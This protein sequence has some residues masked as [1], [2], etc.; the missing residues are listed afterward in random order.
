MHMF[1]P[2]FLDNVLVSSIITWLGDDD[3]IFN[4]DKASCYITKGFKDFFSGKATNI[5][6]MDNKQFRSK[7]NWKFM[8]YLFKFSLDDSSHLRISG[9]CYLEPLW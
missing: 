3:N 4:D 9:N 7:S 8:V 5:N 2:K 1:T 6:D